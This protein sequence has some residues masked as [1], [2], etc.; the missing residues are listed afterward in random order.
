MAHCTGDADIGYQVLGDGYRVTVGDS[1]TT[2]SR[3][4]LVLVV[5]LYKGM[6]SKETAPGG[7]HQPEAGPQVALRWR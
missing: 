3:T 6:V 4:G 7:F 2:S 1:Y 5:V